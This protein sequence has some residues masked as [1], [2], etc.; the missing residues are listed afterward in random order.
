MNVNTPIEDFLATVLY[1]ISTCV[2]RHISVFLHFVHKY[3]RSSSQ[4]RKTRISFA[5]I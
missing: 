1:S 3:W 4:S 2:C 5:V